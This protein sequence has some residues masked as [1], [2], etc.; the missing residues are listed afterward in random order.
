MPQLPTASHYHPIYVWKP[1]SQSLVAV[2]PLDNKVD[3][4]D[5][6]YD[7][8]DDCESELSKESEESEERE[9]IMACDDGK[10]A[11]PNDEREEGDEGKNAEPNQMEVEVVDGFMIRCAEKAVVEEEGPASPTSTPMEVM[12]SYCPLKALEAFTS[13]LDKVGM[14]ILSTGEAKVEHTPDI[15]R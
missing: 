3:P 9:A 2:C 5:E 6:C 8:D 14:E 7:D 13:E 4:W 10:K 15:T 12:D 1:N 11:E